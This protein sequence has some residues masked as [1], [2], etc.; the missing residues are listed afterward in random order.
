M[1]GSLGAG[2]AGRLLVIGFCASLALAGGAETG[3]GPVPREPD[4]S[5]ERF[6]RQ[7]R[8][9]DRP[10]PVPDYA[11]AEQVTG[12]STLD[13][14]MVDFRGRVVVLNFWAT[15]CGVC[16][17]EMPKLD[18]LARRLRTAAAP[19]EV[20]ALSIDR[21]IA[22]AAR[23]LAARGHDELRVFH[24]GQ[25]V[26]A[27]VLGVIGVPTTFVVDSE[28]RAV[29]VSVGPADWDSPAAV[30]WLRS[31]IPDPG[32]SGGAGSGTVAR[33]VREPGGA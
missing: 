19:V 26:L 29:A 30:A 18:A 22:V 31:L 2:S 5:G 25:G 14:A 4:A 3:N 16:R 15:W 8:L 13:H 20:V 12:G 10:L 7:L 33:S 24:D 6:S 11:F 17:K 23:A 9:L 27:P 1:A 28:G 21:D 32:S